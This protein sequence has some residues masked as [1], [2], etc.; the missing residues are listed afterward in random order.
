MAV[1]VC[2]RAGKTYYYSTVSDMQT[3]PLVHGVRLTG[4][5]D[6]DA[7]NKFCQTNKV[8][9]IVDAGHPFAM[10]LHKAVAAQHLP[11]IRV[12]R[13]F[14]PNIE[15]VTYVESMEH[16][17]AMLC[18]EPAKRLLALTGVHSI[19]T[20]SPYWKRYDTL[21]RILDREES[22]AIAQDCDLPER[23]IIYYNRELTLPTT[24]EEMALIEG[25]GCDALLTKESGTAGGFDV[26][27]RAALSLGVRVYV[28]RRPQLP[29]NWIYVEGPHG[30][31]RAIEQEVPSF[32]PLR[33]GFTTGMCATAA[34]KAALVSLLRD[35][36]P[37]I[38]EVS[39]PD[40]EEVTIPVKVE[41]AGRAS[42]V[43]DFSDD[44][45]VTRGC[46]ITS[47]V[48]L[49]T[50]RKDRS[51]VFCKGDGVGTVTLPGLG[52][53]V[54]EP[55]INPTPR[56]CITDE[57]RRLT[58]CAVDVKIDV[59]G[60]EELAR[61]TLN[62]KVGV[63]GGISII[64]TTGIVSPLS[65]E[66]FV[67]SIR[68]ELRVARAIGCTEIA[69]ASG[70]KGEDAMRS[71]GLRTVHYGNFVGETLRIA[72]ELGFAKVVLGI[73]IGK[74]VKLAEGHLD[75]HS[76]VSA[77]NP[78]F[79]KSIAQECGTEVAP[80][81]GWEGGFMARE[82]WHCMPRE[83]FTKIEELCYGVC[84]KVFTKGE[85]KIMLICDEEAY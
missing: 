69:L 67:E 16:A 8:E 59:E 22:R 27:V 7:I 82:L 35:V 43:K 33:T 46:H 83:F 49:R 34:T 50:D 75:T 68:Q 54:G 71:L 37:T 53:D 44:P 78:A 80:P 77:M 21:F 15:G 6:G 76:R 63:E 24:E 74:A 30:L 48:K 3:V 60:G 41:C 62:R 31:R 5:M 47:S 52:I 79:L 39:L 65:N 36:S 29:L 20:L 51:I 40:G 25:T 84:R 66:A 61:R 13:G 10:G 64:G 45:D 55:A 38:I 32:F 18:K 56:K 85:L 26:K 58:D 19:G 14:E 73:L 81:H 4:A 17:A 9:C 28:V 72:E 57:I 42:V 2:E 11:V 12:E 1:D 70:K 23:N